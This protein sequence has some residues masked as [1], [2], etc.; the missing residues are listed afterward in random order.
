MNKKRFKKSSLRQCTKQHSMRSCSNSIAASLTRINAT[1]RGCAPSLATGALAWHTMCP[2]VSYLTLHPVVLRSAI[3]FE[4]GLRI[5]QLTAAMRAGCECTCCHERISH[6][7]DY[8]YH[9]MNKAKKASVGGFSWRFTTPS[10]MLLDVYVTTPVCNTPPSDAV[11]S[12][13]RPHH[14]KSWRER[15][16]KKSSSR[17]C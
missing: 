6:D 9:V 13:D 2:L 1:H 5:P 17:T 12:S 15:R 10:E 16:E 14:T 4:M 7:F 3:A 8:G 11:S